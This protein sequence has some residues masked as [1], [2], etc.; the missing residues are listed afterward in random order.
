[1]L[2]CRD[3]PPLLSACTKRRGL[4]TETAFL[5]ML[6][7]RSAGIESY[8]KTLHFTDQ[9]QLFVCETTSRLLRSLLGRASDSRHGND[10][11]KEAAFSYL[12]ALGVCAH[13][14]ATLTLSSCQDASNYASCWSE[15]EHGFLH[16]ENWSM[17]NTILPPFPSY[18][19]TLNGG[20]GLK[21]NHS[22]LTSSPR[23]MT[24]TR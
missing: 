19:R 2:S 12:H 8:Q 7:R 17:G 10:L 3:S 5:W 11:L 15:A 4:A 16:D 24:P 20:G 1:M 18:R 13:W 22:T 23:F 14:Y 9:P 21:N 6:G